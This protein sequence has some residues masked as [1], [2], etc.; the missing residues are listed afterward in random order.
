MT[1]RIGH[2]T[3]VFVYTGTDDAWAINDTQF[4]DAV[5]LV[6]PN[7]G[8]AGAG[9]IGFTNEPANFVRVGGIRDVD[10]PSMSADEVET[11]SNDSPEQWKEMIA[12]LKDGGDISFDMIY[13]ID[14]AT[15][16]GQGANSFS[17]IFDT[18][19]NRHWAIR[20]PTL[21][22][23]QITKSVGGAD[24][25]IADSRSSKASF[26][27]VNG[28]VNNSVSTIDLDSAA[29]ISRGDVL[30]INNEA[31]LVTGISS[32][33]V[34]VTR[35]YAGTT[36]AAQDD[37]SLVYW[38][39]DVTNGIYRFANN[40]FFVLDGFVKE[41]G[42]SIQMSDVIMRN[43]SLRVSGKVTFPRAVTG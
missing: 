33:T 31:M 25:T 28:G 29:G 35:G 24:R 6:S 11:T 4:A 13:R 43:C 20:V 23:T 39:S 21:A 40:S 16:S 12:G 1:A 26:T 9:Y 27:A 42:Q 34:T 18:Q 17:S 5:P 41:M 3:E 36:A 8:V 14:D 7:K 37:N 2:S 15:Q 30:R 19:R 32:N 10:G 38:G 22:L